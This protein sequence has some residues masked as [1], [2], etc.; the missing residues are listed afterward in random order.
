MYTIKEFREKRGETRLELALA[1]DVTELTV[2]RW[3]RNES[4]PSI[5][6]L[7]KLAEHFDEW[8][9]FGITRPGEAQPPAWVADLVTGLDRANSR[10][11]HLQ[12]ELEDLRNQ[13]ESE[14]RAAE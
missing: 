8:D 7:R 10:L 4:P 13:I 3:E 1:L 14:P 12:L 9:H 6:H 11:E 5:K 2:G